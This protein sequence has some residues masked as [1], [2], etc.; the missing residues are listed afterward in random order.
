VKKQI[1]IG[2]TAFKATCLEVL[3]GLERRAY[4]RVIITRRGKPIAELVPPRAAI[5]QLWGSLRGSLVVA[6]GVDLTEPALAEPL[7]AEQGTMIR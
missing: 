3:R 5:P 1:E 4:D 6:P 2:V 7:D